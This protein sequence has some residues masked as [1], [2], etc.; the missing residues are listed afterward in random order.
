MRPLDDRPV[1]GHPRQ[2]GRSAR[3]AR[4]HERAGQSRLARRQ[5][6]E[7]HSGADGT[8]AHQR[9]APHCEVR[10]ESM[11]RLLRRLVHRQQRP[12]S[13]EM[14]FEEWRGK[15]ARANVKRIAGLRIEFCSMIMSGG[16]TP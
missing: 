8:G 15:V 2:R 10:G 4:A 16:D 5:V 9:G 11:T 13:F 12:Y 6:P 7:V 1:A 3:G 14:W